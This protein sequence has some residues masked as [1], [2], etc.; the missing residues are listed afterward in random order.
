MNNLC[1]RHYNPLN[2]GEKSSAPRF[3]NFASGNVVC[4]SFLPLVIM[5]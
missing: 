2:S 4:I 1:I 5:T 3:T